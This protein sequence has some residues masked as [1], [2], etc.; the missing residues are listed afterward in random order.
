ML[1]LGLSNPET[2]HDRFNGRPWILQVTSHHPARTMRQWSARFLIINRSIKMEYFE[3]LILIS[4]VIS[5]VISKY[6]STN[7]SIVM[8][9]DIN[10]HQVI[11]TSN[12]S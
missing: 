12:R 8:D 7:R 1:H 4:I 5:I 6:Y 3:E 10:I 11:W 2:L 9:L